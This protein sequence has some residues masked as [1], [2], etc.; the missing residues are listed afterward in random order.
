MRN[1]NKNENEDKFSIKKA[2]KRRAVIIS[3]EK[4]FS[5]LNLLV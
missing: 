3:R 4:G 5:Y 1:G 2:A